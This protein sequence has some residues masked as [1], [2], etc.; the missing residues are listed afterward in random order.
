MRFTDAI[1]K[2]NDQDQQLVI[3]Y[4]EIKMQLGNMYSHM[5]NKKQAI[6]DL[7]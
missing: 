2:M 5:Q 3:E 6:A 4:G 1:N 7:K